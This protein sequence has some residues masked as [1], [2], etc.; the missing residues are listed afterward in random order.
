MRLSARTRW[1]L[2]CAVPLAVLGA[3]W[4]ILAPRVD[5]VPGW[6]LTTAMVQSRCSSADLAACAVACERGI[7]GADGCLGADQADRACELG[8]LEGCRL[9][10]LTT[11]PREGARELEPAP[12]LVLLNDRACELGD[13]ASC[14]TVGAWQLGTDSARAIAAYSRW[15]KAE[16]TAEADTCIAEY[17]ALSERAAALWAACDTADVQACGMLGVLLLKHSPERALAAFGKECTLRGLDQALL[18][19]DKVLDCATGVPSWYWHGPRTALGRCARQ[20]A[21]LHWYTEPVNHVAEPRS[22]EGAKPGQVAITLTQVTPAMDGLLAA[23]QSQFTQRAQSIRPCYDRA[24]HAEPEVAGTSRVRMVIDRF[25]DPDQVQV[26]PLIPTGSPKSVH[27][28]ATL[29]DCARKAL[30]APGLGSRRE[31]PVLVEAELAFEP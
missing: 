18:Y 15:C 10:I 24:L 30:S 20:H 9:A 11:S 4:F 3:G 13:A 29:V 14:Q 25:G 8:L 21:L 6:L 22:V 23:L 7:V 1:A 31:S 19:P 16:Q 17:R 28:Q 2:W 12:R 5:G 26:W 27:P